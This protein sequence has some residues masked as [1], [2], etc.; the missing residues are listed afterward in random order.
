MALC[1]IKSQLSNIL[2]L[3][4]PRHIK[5]ASISSIFL[6]T[7]LRDPLFCLSNTINY[8]LSLPYANL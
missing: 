1:A 4:M 7:E 6:A 2:K 3:S 5:I 8:L